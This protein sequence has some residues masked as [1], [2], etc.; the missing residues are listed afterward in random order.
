MTTLVVT[1]EH[2]AALTLVSV[3]GEVDVTNSDQL[4]SAVEEGR[5]PGMPLVFDLSAMT[6]LDSTGLS[7]LLDTHT[8]AQ[9]EGGALLL[10]DVQPMPWRILQ[11]TDVLSRLQI[12]PTLEHA[13]N[14]AINGEQTA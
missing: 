11:I 1:C 13:L 5:R 14:A 3:S 6:F 12:Y 4:R 2:L 10:A 7:V 9:R 8:A